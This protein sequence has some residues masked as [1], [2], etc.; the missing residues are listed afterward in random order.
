[1]S[2]NPS[3]VKDEATSV[4]SHFFIKLRI[5]YVSSSHMLCNWI[6]FAPCNDLLHSI[7]LLHSMSS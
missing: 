6:C 7:A 4:A 5:C 1:M 2:E 3:L